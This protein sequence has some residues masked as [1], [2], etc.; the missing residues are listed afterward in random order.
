MLSCRATA[1]KTLKKIEDFF[2]KMEEKQKNETKLDFFVHNFRTNPSTFKTCLEPVRI[3]S[4]V[5]S[6]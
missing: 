3:P 1:T 6:A 5:T 2:P 4:F